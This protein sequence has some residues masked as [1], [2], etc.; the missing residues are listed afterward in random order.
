VPEQHDRRRT[1]AHRGRQ[2]GAGAVP[3]RGRGGRRHARVED[4]RLPVGAQRR[5]ARGP[6]GPQLPRARGRGPRVPAGLVL[7]RRL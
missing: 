4:D 3:D 5:A 7:R 6:R 1:P 2:P